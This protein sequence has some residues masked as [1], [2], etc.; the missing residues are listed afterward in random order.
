MPISLGTEWEQAVL[1]LPSI[2][3][4][5]IDPQHIDPGSLEVSLLNPAG[6]TT[7]RATIVFSVDTEELKQTVRDTLDQ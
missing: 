4:A 6:P 1:A 2:S 7:V 3:P 5:G